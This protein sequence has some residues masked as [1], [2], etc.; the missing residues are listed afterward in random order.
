MYEAHDIR[1]PQPC[2][3][4]PSRWLIPIGVG[5]GAFVLGIVLGGSSSA[6]VPGVNCQ[7]LSADY[8]ALVSEGID[9]GLSGDETW[10]L[11]V[12]GKRDAL[13]ETIEDSCG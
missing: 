8:A 1:L 3:R 9:A 10:M 2:R 11:E 12:A 7:A 5:L 4:G 6:S 13:R